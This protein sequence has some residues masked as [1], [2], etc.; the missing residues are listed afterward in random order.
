MIRFAALL[1]TLFLFTG[2]H[3]EPTAAEEKTQ[4]SRIVTLAP[5]LA[6]LVFA[7]GAGDSIV[8]VSAYSDF[9]AEVASIPI[10]SDAF[11]VDQ[12]QLALV[13][14]DL[15][16]AWESGMPASTVG[17]I[18]ALGYRVEVIRTRGLSDIAAALRRVGSLTGRDSAG[19]EAARV[20]TQAL[21]TL[22]AANSDKRRLDV[23]YQ[24]SQQPL[25]TV[26]GEHYISEILDICGGNNVFADLDEFAPNVSAEAVIARQPDVILAAEGSTDFDVWRRWETLPAAVS[27]S[28]Y[29]LPADETG[30]PTPRVLVAADEACAALDD[31]RDRVP[32]P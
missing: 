3:D 22:R 29:A 25:Y 16:L 1:A 23:F 9:P 27:E 17:E 13:K 15:L 18:R 24:I 5:H 21:D 11:T 31:A 26:N 32:A 2:C 6:E 28:F 20:F 30:R 19:E 10:V 7:V 8:G 14:P 12:E 4:Y